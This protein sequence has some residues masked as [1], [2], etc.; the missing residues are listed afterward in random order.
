MILERRDAQG[1][2]ASA[3]G[4]GFKTLRDDGIGKVLSGITTL[5]EVLRVT[6]KES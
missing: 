4:Q 3:I 1:I 2:R 5:E 6:Q